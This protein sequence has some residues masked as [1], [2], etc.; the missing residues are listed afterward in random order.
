MGALPI[1]RDYMFTGERRLLDHEE[2]DAR[3]RMAGE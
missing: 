1:V 2:L 3:P